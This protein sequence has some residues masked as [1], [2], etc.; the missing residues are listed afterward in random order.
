M[1]MCI[2]TLAQVIDGSFKGPNLSSDISVLRDVINGLYYVHS[3][4]LVHRNIK[5]E[6]ILVSKDARMKLSDLSFADRITYGS[7]CW[8]AQEVLEM[9]VIAR[10]FGADNGKNIKLKVPPSSDIFSAGCVFFVFLTRGVHPF[11]DECIEQIHNIRKNRPV[12]IE[13]KTN[14]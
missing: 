6:N 1:E 4:K 12:N 5:P 14:L 2:G 13:S 7:C 10:A 11:G 3:A 9:L 8:M